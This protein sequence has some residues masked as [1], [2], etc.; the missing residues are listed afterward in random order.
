MLDLPWNVFRQTGN[1]ETYLLIKELEISEQQAD[2]QPNV[3][4]ENETSDDPNI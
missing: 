4:A 1:I 2:G 3:L